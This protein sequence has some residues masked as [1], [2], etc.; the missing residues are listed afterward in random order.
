MLWQ[1]E[2]NLYLKDRSMNIIGSES[3]CWEGTLERKFQNNIS[4]QMVMQ[5]YLPPM[6]KAVWP[7][8]LSRNSW[9]Q[10]IYNFLL[11]PSEVFP[12][13]Y[14]YEFRNRQQFSGQA[15]KRSKVI[16]TQQRALS[17]PLYDSA[18]DDCSAKKQPSPTKTV[19]KPPCT[20]FAY[21][22]FW[23]KGVLLPRFLMP[24]E[25]VRLLYNNISDELSLVATSL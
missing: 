21:Y 16:G 17:C 22:Q 13:N 3:A 10:K 2:V 6:Q 7:M 18:W 8:T 12:Q 14:F 9:E 25:A 19:K 23:N 1:K 20:L 24:A 11:N 5:E 15:Q 4:I